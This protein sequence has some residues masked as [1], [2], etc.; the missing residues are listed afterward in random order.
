MS[1]GGYSLDQGIRQSKSTEIS[2]FPAGLEVRYQSEKERIR[3]LYRKVWAWHG[4]GRYEDNP[5]R[6]ILSGIADSKEISLHQDVWDGTLKTTET[7]S[8]TKSRPYATLYSDMHIQQ[9]MEADLLFKD[10]R[11]LYLGK[12]T[13][14]HILS[15]FRHAPYLWSQRIPSIEWME[16]K[17]G[18]KIEEKGLLNAFRFGSLRSGIVGDYPILIGLTHDAFEPIKTAGYI[19]AT[20]VRTNKPISIDKITHVEV[21]L[22]YME[23]AST[24]LEKYGI[25][26][27]VLIRELGERYSAEFTDKELVTGKGFAEGKQWQ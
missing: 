15:F 22:K 13:A 26:I 25:S 18:Q 5:P 7:I 3:E 10:H 17:I 11:K 27:P 2:R 6:D 23:H 1:E 19:G 24:L 20:E 9:G 21:P 8:A 4:T 16:R 14:R 12:Q